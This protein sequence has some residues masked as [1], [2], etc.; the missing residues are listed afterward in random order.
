MCSVFNKTE[1]HTHNSHNITTNNLIQ[2][3]MLVNVNFQR[4][5]NALG[6]SINENNG[7]LGSE[8]MQ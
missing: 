3:S 5:R 1:T 2:L 4:I 6:H 8:Y 7:Q